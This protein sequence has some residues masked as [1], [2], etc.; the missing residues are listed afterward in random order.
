M[1]MKISTKAAKL[2]TLIAATI[3]LIAVALM[4]VKGQKAKQTTEND[5]AVSVYITEQQPI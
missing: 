3:L 5:P 2:V 1:K 4:L